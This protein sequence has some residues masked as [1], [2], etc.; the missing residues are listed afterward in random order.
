MDG[1]LLHAV[2]RMGARERPFHIRKSRRTSTLPQWRGERETM[3]EFKCPECGF[4]GTP[5]NRN[6]SCQNTL[7]AALAAEKAR[8]EGLVAAAISVV[9]RSN[10]F[11]RGVAESVEVHACIQE[12]DQA[13]AA[14]RSS[15]GEGSV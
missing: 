9:E 1:G 8:G 3:S 4:T 6:H 15:K 2:R 7:K 11:T 10:M 12:L 13:L 5:R 14:Y